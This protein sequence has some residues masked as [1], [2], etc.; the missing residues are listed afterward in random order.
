VIG[1]WEKETHLGGERSVINWINLF[2]SNE[3]SSC[4]RIYALKNK[5]EI[6]ELVL[7][8]KVFG[9]QGLCWIYAV[10]MLKSVSHLKQVTSVR[11]K[12]VWKLVLL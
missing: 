8:M 4:A 9:I 12:K 6:R 7:I 5:F 10:A 3:Y 2:H 1:S 11:I